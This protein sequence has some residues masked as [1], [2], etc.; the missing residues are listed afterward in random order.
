MDF[1]TNERTKMNFYYGQIISLHPNEIFVF[2]SNPEGRHGAGSA[3]IAKDKFGAQYG[4]GRGLTGSCWALPTKNLT[5][6]YFEKSTEITYQKY[7]ERSI[8]REQIQDNIKDLYDYA[9]ENL[10]VKFYIAYNYGNK[11]LNGYTG[12]EIFEMFSF[13]KIPNNIIFHESFKHK[14]NIEEIW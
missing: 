4:V 7:G 11:N 1:R 14:F 12:D 8:S 10:N 6:N 3:K 2:G 13:H 9:E 5:S